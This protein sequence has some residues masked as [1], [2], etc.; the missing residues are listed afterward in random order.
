[1]LGGITAGS[2]V[3]WWALS[4]SGRPRTGIRTC[5]PSLRWSARLIASIR[6][7]ISWGVGAFG[8]TDL[9]NNLP[10]GR[11]VGWLGQF[12]HARR[13]GQSDCQLVLRF[14]G[15]LVNSPLLPLEQFAVGGM[16]TV[17]GF[18]TN[19]LVRD[20]GYA[21]S[22]EVRVPILRSPDGTALLQ[23]APFIDAGGA[24]YK[25]RATDSPKTLSS[26]GVGLRYDPFPGL[27]AEIYRAHTFAGRDVTNPSRSLQDRG[28]HLVVRADF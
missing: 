26:A 27:H 7:T 10:N 1:M 2:G 6:S 21:A 19:Q 8:A 22:A 28:W 5:S 16:R 17:R 9:G 4:G 18:R 11:F 15:K 23:L 14:D 3:G 24:W 25:G 20:Y 13:I 12:Q